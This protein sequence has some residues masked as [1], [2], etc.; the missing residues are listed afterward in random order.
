MPNI[1]LSWLVVV[2]FWSLKKQINENLILET[3]EKAESAKH[4]KSAHVRMRRLVYI[5]IS[6]SNLDLCVFIWHN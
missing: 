2:L 3:L 1:Y 4:V 5:F 6:L